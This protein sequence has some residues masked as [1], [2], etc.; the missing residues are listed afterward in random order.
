MRYLGTILGI[1]L[2]SLALFRVCLGLLIVA[3][4]II[5]AQALHAHYSDAG[6]LPR[7]AYLTQFANPAHWS[8]HLLSGQWM[9]Q[10]LLFVIASLFAILLIVGYRSRIAIWVSW[11]LLISLQ[12]RHPLLLTGGDVLL[13]MLAFWGLFLPL[14]ARFSVDS[15]LNSATYKSRDNHLSTATFAV[16]AQVCIVYWFTAILKDHAIW[17]SD[18]SAVYYALQVDYFATSVGVWLRQQTWILAPMTIATLCWE[19]VGPVLALAPIR[20]VRCFAVFGFLGLH[21]GLAMTLKIGIFSYVSATAWLLFLPSGFWDRV[22]HRLATPERTGLRLYYDDSCHF[23]RVMVS[24]IRTFLLLPWA[25]L[26]PAQEDAAVHTAML[27]NRS[28][29]VRDHTGERYFH[30]DAVIYVCKCSPLA[31]P[32][33]HFLRWKPIHKVGFIAY[34]WI[35][36]RRS[37]PVLSRLRFR[38]LSFRQSWF[39]QILAVVVLIYVVLWNL[40]TTNFP[41]WSSYFPTHWNWPGR[42]LRIEQQW[43][44]FAPKPTVED[45]WFVI[46]GKLLDGSEVDLLTGR[47]TTWKKPA[48]VSATFPTYRWRKYM[49][50]LWNKDNKEY[51]RFYGKY[52]CRSWNASHSGD[53]RLNTLEIFFMLE[54]TH[55]NHIAK[56]EKRR[57]WRHYCFVKPQHW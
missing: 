10:A 8:V 31:F 27:E 53:Q 1:D 30:F 54:M 22:S 33:A 26:A 28:W 6:V 2:R 45:G 46:P 34:Q 43:S 5:R 4:L 32:F 47:P 19:F 55:R 29:I 13:R 3:D 23:C 35:A 42:L 18:F 16:L 49:V 7:G 56:P 39:T 9:F 17:R 36:K 38:P 11:L 50:N 51:R 24:L 37:F 15:A 44:M 40:R 57:I 41:L 12:N 48:L 52:L 20:I 25:Q 21:V 14:G